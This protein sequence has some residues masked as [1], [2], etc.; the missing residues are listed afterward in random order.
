[1]K[2][3]NM[4]ILGAIVVIAALVLLYANISS[5][6]PIKIKV[7]DKLR[8][9]YLKDKNFEQICSETSGLWMMETDKMAEMRNGIPISVTPCSGCMPNMENMFCDQNKYLEYVK[10]NGVKPDEL[11]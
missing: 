3:N 2:I 10:L 11:R 5:N 7:G 9:V 6:D 4:A 8:E 1:M